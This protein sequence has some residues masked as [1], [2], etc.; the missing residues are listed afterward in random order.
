MLLIKWLAEFSE[1]TRRKLLEKSVYVNYY[2]YY[3]QPKYNNFFIM[4]LL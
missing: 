4:L 3:E 2:I 1:A